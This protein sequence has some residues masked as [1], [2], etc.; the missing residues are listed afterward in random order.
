MSSPD[1]AGLANHGLTVPLQVADTRY[2]VRQ[3][4]PDPR[5][6]N[7]PTCFDSDSVL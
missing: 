6:G 5:Q 4:T 3:G 2:S 7:N 1:A